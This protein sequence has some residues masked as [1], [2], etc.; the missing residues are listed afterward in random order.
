M[1]WA[2]SLPEITCIAGLQLCLFHLHF[3]IVPI[4]L[5]CSSDDS[6]RGYTCNDGCRTE[7]T[8]VGSGTRNVCVRCCTGNECNKVGEAYKNETET[9]AFE[10]REHDSVVQRSGSHNVSGCKNLVAMSLMWILW[11]LKSKVDLEPWKLV[12]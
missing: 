2:L 3:S 6:L 1:E 11:F 9:A 8:L 12:F 10:D 4:M 7:V 5:G